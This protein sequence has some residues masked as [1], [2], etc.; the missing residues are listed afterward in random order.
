[1]SLETK[2]KEKEHIRDSHALQNIKQEKHWRL[3]AYKALT[4]LAT[5]L[6]NSEK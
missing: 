2:N 5:V 1:M 4:Q 3:V 6:N